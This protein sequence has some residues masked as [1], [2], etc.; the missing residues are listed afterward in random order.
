[1]AGVLQACICTPPAFLRHG[2]GLA[3]IVHMES[4]LLGCLPKDRYASVSL[5]LP[6][7]VSP[8]TVGALSDL[9]R[10]KMRMNGRS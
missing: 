4:E 10:F 6:L 3:S 8:P 1:M 2:I 7:K 9:E 5:T